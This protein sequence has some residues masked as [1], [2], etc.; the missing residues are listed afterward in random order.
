[1]FWLA[2]SIFLC[3][4]S[5]Q[6]GFGSFRYPGP[7]FLPFCSGVVLGTFAIILLIISILKRKGEETVKNLWKG[8][9]LNKV[10]VIVISLLAYAAL[11]TSLGYLIT[12]FVLMVF[13]FGRIGTTRLWI[14]VASA[15]IAAV[16]S[17]MAFHVWLEVQLPKGI[18]GL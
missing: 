7:G 18:F 15:F 14:R 9:E 1:M 11:L 8:I 4:E 12:T 5:I 16:G 2:L 6:A 13:L 10:I 3:I 17:Y